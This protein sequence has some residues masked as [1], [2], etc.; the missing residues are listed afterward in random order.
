M[1]KFLG[2]S[3]GFASGLF[4]LP[5]YGT[6]FLDTVLPRNP[7]TGAR[8]LHILP[9]SYEIRLRE[10]MYEMMVENGGGEVYS[11]SGIEKE[12]V[13]WVE[14]I[15]GRLVHCAKRKGLPYEIKV[16]DSSEINAWCLP[17]GKVGI[18]WGLLERISQVA[19]ELKG[20]GN[21]GYT[22]PDYPTDSISYKE[23]TE[24]DLIAAVLAHEIT[25]ADARHA[26]RKTEWSAIFQGI[27]VGANFIIENFLEARKNQLKIE[28]SEL[29]GPRVFSEEKGIDPNFAAE[30][31]T[32]EATLKQKE[33]QKGWIETIQVIQKVVYQVLMKFGKKLYDLAGRRSHEH[34]ADIYGSYLAEDANFKSQAASLCMM[35]ILKN[36][37]P[38]KKEAGLLGKAYNLISTHPFF[39]DRQEK[40]FFRPGREH[41]QIC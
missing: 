39:E 9:E 37:A 26:A 21:F 31:R 8:Q 20:E 4:S 13:E 2:V 41:L 15:F 27:V 17:G 6:R 34:E 18:C 12:R 10:S 32:R 28:I 35:D 1:R 19:E 23:L 16:I 33:S 22:H 38:D 3:M 5:S 30:E 24:E 14:Q 40:L 25:H 29:S 11:S 7:V 36:G